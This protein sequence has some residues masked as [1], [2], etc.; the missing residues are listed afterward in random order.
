M[1]VHKRVERWGVAALL[2]CTLACAPEANV[3]ETKQAK[4][5]GCIYCHSGAYIAVKTPVHVGVNPIT[6][7]DCHATNA[8]KPTIGGGGHPEELFPIRAATS[9]HA[10]PAI[11][12]GD[13]HDARLGDSTGGQNTDCIHCHIGAHTIASVD[14]AHAGRPGYTPANPNSPNS[15]LGCHPSGAK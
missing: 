6:C 12:C 1:G 9:K 3:H 7:G 15:C 4:S 13:C 5:Q 2:A 11:G 10:N 8:W 14:Q